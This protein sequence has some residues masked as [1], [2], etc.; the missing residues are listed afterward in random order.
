M[1][2]NYWDWVNRYCA[3]CPVLDLSPRL[4]D[5]KQNFLLIKERFR[6]A[7]K[8]CKVL[9]ARKINFITARSRSNV[10]LACSQMLANTIQYSSYTKLLSRHFYR[11]VFFRRH[12]QG[13]RRERDWQGGNPT[14]FL[15]GVIFLGCR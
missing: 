7:K 6:L 3:Y 11:R 14:T 4:L 8:I 15:L 10:L 13:P 9:A 2:A 5:A 12:F 1:A